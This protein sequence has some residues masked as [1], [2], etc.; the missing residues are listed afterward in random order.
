MSIQS[1]RGS[2]MLCANNMLAAMNMQTASS[3]IQALQEAR[4]RTGVD[5]ELSPC[6]RTE[7]M[8]AGRQTSV[9]AAWT[10][11]MPLW[12]SGADLFGGTC[13]SGPRRAQRHKTRQRAA[14]QQPPDGRQPATPRLG[15]SVPPG[16]IPQHTPQVCRGRR[17]PTSVTYW[18]WVLHRL[19]STA[20]L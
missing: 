4:P 17:A 9:C 5:L 13:P 2:I 20:T 19:H 12:S 11:R 15:L 1:N 6:T 8:A 3:T 16:C 18:L 14:W 10:R 7:Q